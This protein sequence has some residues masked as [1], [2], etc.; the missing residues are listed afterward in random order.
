M[1]YPTTTLIAHSRETFDP[2]TA[3]ARTWRPG[4]AAQCQR[5]TVCS[6]VDDVCLILI[7]GIVCA[8][9]AATYPQPSPS[10]AARRA[11][12]PVQPKELIA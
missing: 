4:Q 5:C 1:V 3:I 11:G 12:L 7:P 10:V 6:A 2:H 9:D 8:R